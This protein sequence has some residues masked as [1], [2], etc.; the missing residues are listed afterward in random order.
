MQGMTVYAVGG[1]AAL[2]AFLLGWWLQRQR[3]E[4][5]LGDARLESER[6]LDAANREADG[7]RKTAE[8][9][10]KDEIFRARQKFESETDATRRELAKRTEYLDQRE[11]QHAALEIRAARTRM[12]DELDKR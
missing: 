11:K 10:A 8:L 12:K 1:A 6:L 7:I 4:R 2:V 9:E 3:Q 5:L